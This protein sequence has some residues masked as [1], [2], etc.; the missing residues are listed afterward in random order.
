MQQQLNYHEGNQM[1]IA[2]LCYAKKGKKEAAVQL[3]I[4]IWPFPKGHLRTASEYKYG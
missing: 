2:I 4:I 1:S 3:S